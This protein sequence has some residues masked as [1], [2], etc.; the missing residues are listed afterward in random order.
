MRMGLKSDPK[1][2]NENGFT[3]I[4][5]LVVVAIISILA[6]VSLPVYAGPLEKARLAHDQATVRILNSASQAYA[7]S[8]GKAETEIFPAAS[9]DT[10]KIE[11]LHEEGYLDR[12]PSPKQPDA[13]FIF[14]QANGF[15]S[16][17]NGVLFSS[18]FSSMS[19][20]EKQPWWTKCSSRAAYTGITRPL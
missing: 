16:L 12:V 20:T 1:H 13:A 2:L 15:W 5:I 9:S 8:Q 4:E 14:N 17:S 3:L 10:A 6:A 7:L 19:T 11:L 18:D